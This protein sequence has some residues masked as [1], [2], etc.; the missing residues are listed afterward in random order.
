MVSLDTIRQNR[1]QI[2]RIAEKHKAHNVRV[3]GSF[4]RDEADDQSDL[5]LLVRMD[6]G[7]SIFSSPK[8]ITTGMTCSTRP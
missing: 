7:A 4:V 5:D 3:F 8:W 1:G 6:S 2:V